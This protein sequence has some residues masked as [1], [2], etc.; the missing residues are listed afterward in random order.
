MNRPDDYVPVTVSMKRRE[1]A[2][3]DTATKRLDVTRSEFA[4]AMLLAGARLV[5]ETTDQGEEG[6]S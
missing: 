6:E 2:V 5:L 3:V 4:C 1:L